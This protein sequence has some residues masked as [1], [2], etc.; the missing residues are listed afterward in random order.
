MKYHFPKQRTESQFFPKKPLMSHNEAV[1]ESS[2]CIRCYNAPCIQGC[3]TEINI[4]Q[5][6][7]R[8][9]DKNFL[10]SSDTILRSN[11]LGL[12]CSKVCPV[13]VLCEG[14]CVY[15]NMDEP[16]IQIGRLQEYALQHFYQSPKLNS[17]IEKTNR[18][19]A[20]IGAGPA[21]LSCASYLALSGVKATIF[22]K[23]SLAGGLN[24]YGIAPYKLKLEESI[25]EIE[26]VQSLGVEILL[27][28]EV[29]K[30]IFVSELQKEYD[31]IFIGVGLGEDTLLLDAKTSEN[32]F[33]AL[34]VVQ[35]I[36]TE[37]NLEHQKI[38]NA[39]VV[40]GG[41]T[42]LDIAQELAELGVQVNLAYRK[43]RKAMSGYKHELKQALFKGV[44]FWE[45][46]EP[47]ALIKDEDSRIKGMR[48]KTEKGETEIFCD[49]L[50][51]ATGQKK[52]P[53]KELFPQI[54]LNSDGSLVINEHFETSIENVYAGGDCANGGKEVVNAVFEGRESAY[55]M[56]KKWN[57]KVQYGKNTT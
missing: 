51:F 19:V 47:Q 34:S 23:N 48:F 50:I 57:L 33:G 37:M 8:I 52:Y 24:S 1:V 40:G 44:Q 6:I 3:P 21:S 49:W 15:N 32:V 46:Y 54:D 16:P 26:F 9:Q 14:A 12:S 20:L 30:S 31:A 4:P 22:E 13:E 38:G 2:R 28:Q 36:K 7:K 17:S 56:L 53:I 5:F 39:L 29:G 55:R 11:I 42:A 35:K 41:N 45:M 43:S 25:K 10:G 27:N 18:K